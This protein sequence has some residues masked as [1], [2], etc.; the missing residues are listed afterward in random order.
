MNRFRKKAGLV[1]LS[2]PYYAKL[3]Y[4][5]FPW[6]IL[7][8]L[9]KK[10]F[11][12]SGYWFQNEKSCASITQTKK[13]NFLIHSNDTRISIF[14]ILFV[15][16]WSNEK[17]QFHYK[18]SNPIWSRWKYSLVLFHPNILLTNAIALFPS[19][20]FQ[21]VVETTL[22]NEMNVENAIEL[23]WKVNE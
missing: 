17:N 4:S 5:S 13:F 18:Y 16:I 7:N 8:P 21:L 2:K 20:K 23:K 6:E 22:Y 10:N 9:T 1:H 19:I 3:L 14:I 11:N 15:L 12:S